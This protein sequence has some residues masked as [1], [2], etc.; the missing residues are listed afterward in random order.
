MIRFI[1]RMTTLDALSTDKE[2]NLRGS[3]KSRG[4]KI[5]NWEG[6][7]EEKAIISKD[8]SLLKRLKCEQI[9]Q[10]EPVSFDF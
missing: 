7:G 10:S 1:F 6:N 8:I 4:L 9:E 2:C 3:Y 5:W